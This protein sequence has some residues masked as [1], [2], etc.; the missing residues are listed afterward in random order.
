MRPP[1][2]LVISLSGAG[3]HRGAPEL[4]EVAESVLADERGTA[5]AEAKAE[6]GVTVLARTLGITRQKVYD[7]IARMTAA[8][9]GAS[10]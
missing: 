6:Q 1:T 5:M 7:A 9:E 10:R 8:T 2:D 3:T 4:I